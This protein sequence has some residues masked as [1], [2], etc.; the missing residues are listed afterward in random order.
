LATGTL[1]AASVPAQGEGSGRAPAVRPPRGISADPRGFYECPRDGRGRVPGIAV[2]LGPFLC[3]VCGTLTQV[4]DCRRRGGRGALPRDTVH[5][6]GACRAPRHAPM[7]RAP[8][9]PSRL[10]PGRSPARA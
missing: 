2:A 3:K 9:T 10:R 7:R 8:G 1:R 5:K 6:G 4:T